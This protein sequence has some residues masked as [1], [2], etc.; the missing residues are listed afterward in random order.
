LGFFRWINNEW[1]ALPGALIFLGV[2]IVLTLKTGFM[3]IR[4][5]PRFLHL[6]FNG[7]SEKQNSGRG[8]AINPY[9]ALFTALATSIGMGNVVGPTVAVSVGGPGALFWLLVYMF[10]A[11]ITKFTEVTFAMHTRIRTADGKLIGGPMEYLKSVH[12]GLAIWYCVIMTLIFAIWSGNQ[13]NTLASICA[14]ESV[15]RWSIGLG[16]AVFAGI[17][18]S[19]GAKRIGAIASKLVPVMFFLYVSFALYI[20]FKDVHCLI[21]A[22]ALIKNH[23]FTASAPIGGFLGASVMQAMRYGVFRAVYISESGLGTSSIA[24]AMSDAQHPVDQGL[25]AM[26]STIADMVL[27]ILSGLLVL[28]TG[29]WMR[30]E[31]SNTLVYEVFK[32]HA[33]FAGQIVLLISISLFVLTTIIGN[34]FNGVKSFAALSKG[35]WINAYIAATVFYIFLGAIMPVPLLWEMM[36]TLMIFAAIPNLVGLLILAYRKPAV[37]QLPQ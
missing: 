9:H 26:G 7:V 35:R 1:F 34:S 18:L 27:S 10:F 29:F 23:I 20:L 25:L 4:G 12:R 17:V 15:P 14:L 8:D 31:V 5:F 16:L 36:D 6:I 24:H 13:S 2:S 32:E 22:L 28:V 11:S 19:G 30:G 3:Q 33:P 21:A 37:L